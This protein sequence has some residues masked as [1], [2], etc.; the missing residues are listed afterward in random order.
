VKD[1]RCC[2]LPGAVGRWD[3]VNESGSGNMTTGCVKARRGR[4]GGGCGARGLPLRRRCLTVSRAS[5]VS[6][7]WNSAGTK[8]PP[9]TYRSLGWVGMLLSREGAGLSSAPVVANLVLCWDRSQQ[10]QLH[11][12]RAVRDGTG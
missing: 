12:G 6:P 3:G 4:R 11:H 10:N 8:G 9:W 7:I 5:L 2:A 1:V